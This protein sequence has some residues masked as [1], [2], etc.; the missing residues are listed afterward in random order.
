MG[1]TVQGCVDVGGVH[2]IQREGGEVEV[3]IGQSC[4]LILE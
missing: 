2:L 1:L 3:T 4:E